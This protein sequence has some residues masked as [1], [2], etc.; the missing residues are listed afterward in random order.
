MERRK[1]QNIVIIIVVWVL[2][3]AIGAAIG[4][5]WLWS[6]AEKFQ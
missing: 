6:L 2:A 3:L 4:C 1:L 5:R